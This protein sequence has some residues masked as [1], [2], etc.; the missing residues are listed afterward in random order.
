LDGDM[1]SSLRL[2][3]GFRSAQY[4]ESQGRNSARIAAGGDNSCFRASLTDAGIT[5]LCNMLR[6]EEMI[7]VC[8]A[9]TISVLVDTIQELR[10]SGQRDTILQSV[11]RT[12][13]LVCRSW[14]GNAQGA[15][16][17]LVDEL[18]A[19]MGS[20]EW[21]TEEARKLALAALAALMKRFDMSQGEGNAYR[22]SNAGFDLPIIWL[23]RMSHPARHHIINTEVADPTTRECRY[24][25][26]RGRDQ[27]APSFRQQCWRGLDK[28]VRDKVPRRFAR[29]VSSG[30]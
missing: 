13:L 6:S 16:P 21:I 30:R 2:R 19:V 23:S 25:S 4:D 5:H 11:L 20:E 26:E 28:G 10:G 8:E 18:L 22:V 7:V 17:R 27:N 9:P 29:H 14:P 3:G 1:P 12:L 24:R 15:E